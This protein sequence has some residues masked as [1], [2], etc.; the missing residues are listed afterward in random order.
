MIQFLLDPEF[1]N[2]YYMYLRNYLGYYEFLPEW[3]GQSQTIKS[4]FPSTVSSFQENYPYVDAGDFKGTSNLLSYQLMFNEVK[5]SDLQYNSSDGFYISQ[6]GNIRMQYQFCMK[7]LIQ[8][9]G[10][11]HELRKFHPTFTLNAKISNETKLL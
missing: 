2:D 10:Y 7:V 8:D 3:Y 5:D 1:Y 11:Y 6:D 4:L 9:N